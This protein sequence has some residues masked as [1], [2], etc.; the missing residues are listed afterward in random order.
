MRLLPIGRLALVVFVGAS[1]AGV[2]NHPDPAGPRFA[3]AYAREADAPVLRLAT[4]NIKY[5]RR[6]DRA[7]A[8]FRQ[9]PLLA[10]A[11]VIVL[12]EMNE[13]AVDEMAAA[14]H[15][16]Y[17]YYPGAYHPKS[18][19]NFG[20]AILSRWPITDDRK[21]LLPHPGRFRKMQRIAVSA[22]VTVRGVPVR[23]YSVHLETPGAISAEHR[24]EQVAAIVND[25][26]ESPRVIVAGDFNNTGTVAEALQAAGY[27]WISRGIGR[28]IGRFSWD[29][30][31]A[32]GLSAK[33]RLSSAVIRDN[34][35]ASD[36]KPVWAE[37]ALE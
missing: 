37:V 23:I 7:V 20:N 24:R 14:L 10:G 27:T 2:R 8:L 5:A 16:D 4:F 3:G 33:S 6:M 15:L 17:V 18:H 35:G 11:D 1:C 25:A 21:V 9:N 31:F 19:G 12:Q 36:H 22:T 30:V 13:A 26:G 34:L 29:H 28:T 32:R